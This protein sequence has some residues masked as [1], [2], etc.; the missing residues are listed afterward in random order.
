MYFERMRD[1]WQRRELTGVRVQALVLTLVSIRSGPSPQLCLHSSQGERVWRAVYQQ[2][3][4]LKGSEL[5]IPGRLQMCQQGSLHKNK[6]W[7]G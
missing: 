3:G 4:R 7:F 1:V 5:P 2:H 6:S